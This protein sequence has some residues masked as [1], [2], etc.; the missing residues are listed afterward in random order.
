MCERLGLNIRNHQGVLACLAMQTVFEPLNAAGSM[1][2]QSVNV[3]Q[4]AAA[5][6]GWRGEPFA[7][8][9]K[10]LM[11][12]VIISAFD[13]NCAQRF[14]GNIR[15]TASGL[16]GFSEKL[17]GIKTLPTGCAVEMAAKKLIEMRFIV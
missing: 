11:E 15:P 14:Y 6:A 16:D 7:F 1:L 4:I 2:R 5:A 3:F 12:I 8:D 13:S 17:D 9:G 10:Q